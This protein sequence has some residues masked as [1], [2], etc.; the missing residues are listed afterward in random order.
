M[1]K[2]KHVLIL[3]L[4]TLGILIPEGLHI[5]NNR[6]S[7]RLQLA[8]ILQS[9]SRYEA[10]FT[11]F[12]KASESHIRNSYQINHRIKK[13]GTYSKNSQLFIPISTYLKSL[14]YSTI[15]HWP[16]KW[17]QPFY[18][19]GILTFRL[20][21]TNLS[22][23][24]LTTATY[25]APDW[26]NNYVELANLYQILGDLQNARKTISRCIEHYIPSD[27][28][29]S[30]FDN[31]YGKGYLSPGFTIYP[32]IML[33]T[34]VYYL[35]EKDIQKALFFLMELA[36]TSIKPIDET[37][38][39]INYQLTQSPLKKSFLQKHESYLDSVNTSLLLSE[40][41]NRLAIV[42]YNM[43]LISSQN[44]E[45][46]IAEECFNK[47]IH[48]STQWSY[49]DIELANWYMHKGDRSK[50]LEVIL[51]CQEQKISQKYCKNYYDTNISQGAINPVGFLSDK[52]KEIE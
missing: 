11:Q 51:R 46:N 3:T 25:L 47:A 49:F 1:F 26:S 22:I 12:E 13:I 34:Y 28:C 39:L 50:A 33:D 24:Y 43:A 44:D 30:Y 15:E 37:S 40:S 14:D 52:I 38:A 2:T 41:Q 23:E 45:E 5:F 48:L 18:T 17:A 10:A 19:I 6:V 8:Q 9:K 31:Y 27:A 4:V 36:D 7:L 20:G 32:N 21:D 42:F 35:E 29:Q 16:D